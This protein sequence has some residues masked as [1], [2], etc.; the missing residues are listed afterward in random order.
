MFGDC[1]G[2]LPGLSKY[3][4]AITALR[5]KEQKIN[6]GGIVITAL[7][8]TTQITIMSEPDTMAQFAFTFSVVNHTL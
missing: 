5:G 3:K 2:N 6:I 4:A 1:N 7:M 8:T